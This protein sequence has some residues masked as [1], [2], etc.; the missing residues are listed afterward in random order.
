VTLVVNA[1]AD[2]SLSATPSSQTVVAGTSTSYTAN[3]T[4]NGGFTGSVTFS[5][6][7]LPTGATG[8]FSP[9]PT[10]GNSST[11]TLTTSATTPAG[12]Y[13][14]TITGTSGT[15]THSTVVTLLVNPVPVGDFLLSATPGSRRVSTGAS[16]SYTVN[17]S[18]TGGFT[19]AVNFTVTGLPP[20]ATGSFSPNPSN[21]ANATL[22]VTTSQGTPTGSPVLTIT[23]T[24]GALTHTTTVRLKV[25]K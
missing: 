18:R 9:N 16:T 22:T 3:I 13:Q 6:S 14:V 5:A 25:S 11:L 23:G 1:P 8:T 4:R 10:T 24:S 21:G 15:L 7:G 17:I 20:L 2:F 12:S 19:G